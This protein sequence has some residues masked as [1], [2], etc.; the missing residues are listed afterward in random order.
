MT[1][2]KPNENFKYYMYF[3]S[4]RMNI[5]WKKYHGEEQPYTNDPI[6]RVHKFTNVYRVL[7][8][9]SQYLL[10]NVIYNGKKYTKEDMF[11]RIILYKNYNLPKTWDTLVAGL[12]DITL[13]TPV[14]DIYECLMILNKYAPVYSNAYMLTC[15]F[16]RNET[17]LKNYDLKI[18]NPKFLLYLKIFQKDLLEKGVMKD[19]FESENFEGLFNNLK[20]VLSFGD[21]LAYQMAQDLNYTDFFNFEENDFCA[22]G[23]GTQR[24]VDKCFDVTGGKTDYNV[25]IKWVHNNFE[26]LLEDYK[27]E[28]NGLP[29]WLPKVPD[30]SNNFCE[31]SKYLKGVNPGTADGD[32]RIKQLFKENSNKMDLMLPPKW[33]VNL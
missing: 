5:F 33:N 31:T 7:D 25:V 21:F 17:F 1:N 18:G 23:P 12:G 19:C 11:W 30:L 32:K 28:F 29:N 6:L 14:E 2:F 26:Q 27:I 4:E 16:M 8:R 20:K 13:A 15:P 3:V 22:A 24:G 10:K 9:S